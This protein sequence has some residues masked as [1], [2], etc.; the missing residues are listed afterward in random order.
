MFN[1]IHI[2]CTGYLKP[3]DKPDSHGETP[4]PLFSPI[5]ALSGLVFV[6]VLLQLI[7][8]G[9]GGAAAAH[10]STGCRC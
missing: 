7:E 6:D 10:F 5:P 3:S 1:E 2:P 4:D 9:E 8:G